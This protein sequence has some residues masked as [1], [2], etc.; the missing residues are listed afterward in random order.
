MINPEPFKRLF[1]LLILTENTAV[2][3]IVLFNTALCFRI[4]VLPSLG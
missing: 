2:V 1:A 3:C 4:R